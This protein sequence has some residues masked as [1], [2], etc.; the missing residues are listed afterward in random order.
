MR[1]MGT[2]PCLPAFFYLSTG[3]PPD[4]VTITRCVRW[5]LAQLGFG[6]TAI[7]AVNES[8][9]CL[10]GRCWNSGVQDLGFSGADP[11]FLD[12]AK[13]IRIPQPGKRE[14]P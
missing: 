2:T 12:R 11:G 9:G 3:Y 6:A 8:E 4:P 1:M 7:E 5:A 13:Y 14:I 10:G